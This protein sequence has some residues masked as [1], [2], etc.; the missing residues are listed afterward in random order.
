MELR[1]LAYFVR[2]AEL[3]SL[4]AAADRLN[5]SQ[6]SLSR[7]MRMLEDELGVALFRRHRR[8]MRLTVD[9]EDLHRRIAAPLGQVDRALRDLRMRGARQ[10]TSIVLGMPPSVGAVLAGPLAQRGA[11]DAPGLALRMVEAYAGHLA[12]ALGSGEIG[13]ALL[14]GMPADWAETRWA[15]D[16]AGLTVHELLVEPLV[17]VGPAGALDPGR[18]VDAEALGAMALVL[19]SSENQPPFLRA[20]ELEIASRIGRPLDRRL[21]ADSF[22]LMRQFIE[23]GLGHAFLPL[24]SVTREVESGR[25]SWAP[26]EG[27]A[28]SRQLVLA[29]RADSAPAES[30]ALLVETVRNAVRDLVERGDWQATL[31]FRTGSA[32]NPT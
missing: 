15:T 2:I 14:Y 5:V 18:P 25:L 8:G 10:A 31:L 16:L 24:S 6:P 17:L 3:G 12:T 27:L 29:T 11:A 13:A 4:S 19:P 32:R 20:L 1:R 28:A 30:L 26:L 9:G 23:T 21:S 7:Q 22:Q